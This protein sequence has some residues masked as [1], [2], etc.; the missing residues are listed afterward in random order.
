ML[1]SILLAW[2]LASAALAAQSVEGRVVNAATGTGIP[3]AQVRILPAPNSS[4]EYS[5][6]AKTDAQGRFRIEPIDEGAYVA[7]YTAPGFSPVPEPGS[8]SPPFAVTATGETVR[9]EARMQPMGRLSG[10]VLDG[11]G[12]PVADAGIWLIGGDHWCKPPA[13]FPAHQQAKTNE[14]GEYTIANVTAGKWLLSATAPSTWSPPEPRGDEPLGWRQTFYPGAADPQLAEAVT[15]QPGAEL[16]DRNIK[17]AAGPV[18]AIRGRV[19]DGRGDGV[20]KASV[21]LSAAFGPTL[22]QATKDDGSFEFPA[23]TEDEWRV[24]A[25]LERGSVK[26]RA[27]QVLEMR[28][29]DVEKVELRLAAPFTLRGKVV[30]MVPDGV[31]AAKPGHIDISLIS[32]AA[33]LSDLG[34]AFRPGEA[35]E[36]GLTIEDVYPGPYQVRPL[37]DAPPPYYLDSIRLGSRDASGPDVPILSDAEPLTITYK[38]GGGTVRGTVEGCGGAHLFLIPQD[39][40][41]QRPG[42]MRVANCDEHG[43]FEFRAVRPGEYY[44][45]GIQWRASIVSY[46]AL[47]ADPEL[48][49]QAGKVTVRDN[50]STA[51]DI[52][53]SAR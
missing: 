53:L 38:Q 22:T 35:D 19:L 1:R 14:K 24:S 20:A 33:Q 27:R 42:F 15:V 34:E 25:I 9:L 12:R 39:A 23:V 3:G 44:A 31:P 4:G 36:D 49:K 13:C 2:T 50:E 30:M 32:A 28:G 46:A 45:F 11:A 40:A 51:A 26:L 37:G 43:R 10:R 16:W 48:L 41:L 47:L 5:Y 18:H 7:R 8:V 21:A 29:R 52:R 6:T 17:L